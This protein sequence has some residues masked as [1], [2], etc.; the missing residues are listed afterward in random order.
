MNLNVNCPAAMAQQLQCHEAF[1]DSKKKKKK[2][3]NSDDE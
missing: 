2:E 1:K 3:R